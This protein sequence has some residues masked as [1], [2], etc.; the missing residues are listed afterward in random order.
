MPILLISNEKEALN[1]AKELT[2]NILDKK[3]C[4]EV[5]SQNFLR[6]NNNISVD[7]IINTINDL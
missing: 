5:G 2:L 7:N 3:G 4:G 6:S 1:R